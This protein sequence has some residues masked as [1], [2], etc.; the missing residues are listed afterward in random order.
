MPR[1]VLNREQII[2][3]AISLLDSEGVKGLS[4][5]RLGRL[6]GGA[7][8]AAY[9]HIQSR[10]NLLALAADYVWQEVVLPD[11]KTIGWR[12]A[13]R[14]FAWDTYTLLNQH[15]WLMIAM[16]EHNAY[17]INRARHQEYCYIILEDAGF[18][19]AALDSAVSVLLTFIFGTAFAESMDG[20]EAALIAN[21]IPRLQTRIMERSKLNP[22]AAKKDNFTFGLNVV[23]DGLKARLEAE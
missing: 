13:T 14:T 16:V 21:Q 18:T 9:W 1:D 3:A 2:K 7:T 20:E 22:D 19:D 5:R 17:G 15:P 10:E 12:E 8:T 4:M 6:L 11:C 23:I